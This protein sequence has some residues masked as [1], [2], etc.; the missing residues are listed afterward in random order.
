MGH[1]PKF[2]FVFSSYDSKINTF[3]FHFNLLEI[4]SFVVHDGKILVKR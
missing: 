4:S 3:I 1:D 2:I